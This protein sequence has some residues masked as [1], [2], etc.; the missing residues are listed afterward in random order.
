MV[1]REYNFGGFTIEVD[2][3]DP[4]VGAWERLK[5]RF[6][7]P[8][9]IILRVHLN[10]DHRLDE[11]RRREMEYELKS[12]FGWGSLHHRPAASDSDPFEIWLAP[13]HYSS[14]TVQY[15]ADMVGQALEASLWARRDKSYCR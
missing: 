2:K 3:P 7:H 9:S 15:L 13:E 8:P 12:E 4:P 14:M 6:L 11:F 10:G 5:D 1:I